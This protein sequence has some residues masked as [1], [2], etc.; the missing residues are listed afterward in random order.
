MEE[1][2][3]WWRTKGPGREENSAATSWALLLLFQ[4]T[5]WRVGMRY[6]EQRRDKGLVLKMGRIGLQCLCGMRRNTSDCGTHFNAQLH[7]LQPL[8]ASKYEWMGIRKLA[9]WIC[10]AC[11]SGP[12]T[13]QPARNLIAQIVGTML[14]VSGDWQWQYLM[15]IRNPQ[16]GAIGR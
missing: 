5:N 4:S 12:C 6:P 11:V 13:K 3:F 2:Q 14:P 7:T 9:F 15:F 10:A 16:L 8:I 1:T